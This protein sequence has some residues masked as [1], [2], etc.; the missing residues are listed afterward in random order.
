MLR[1]I[2]CVVP[3]LLSGRS[4]GT[5]FLGLALF[6]VRQKSRLGGVREVGLVVLI[7][8]MYSLF[9]TLC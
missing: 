4:M 6:K 1:D 2:S 8:L 5:V 3:V 9:T 7:L